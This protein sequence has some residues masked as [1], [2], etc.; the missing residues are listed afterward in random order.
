VKA[1]IILPARKYYFS[2]KEES[3]SYK[4]LAKLILVFSICLGVTVPAAAL[5]IQ[6]EDLYKKFYGTDEGEKFQESLDKIM[7]DIVPPEGNQAQRTQGNA[8]V[9]YPEALEDYKE[10]MRMMDNSQEFIYI[11]TLVLRV[12]GT[13]GMQTAAKMM[14]KKTFDDVDGAFIYHPLSQ[15]FY[16]SP[17]IVTA[18]SALG[19]QCRGYWPRMKYNVLNLY[20]YLLVGC[21]KKLMLCDDPD[22]GVVGIV[23]G[24]NLGDEYLTDIS[25]STAPEKDKPEIEK[26]LKDP[27]RWREANQWRDTD[28]VVY[29]PFTYDLDADFV[30]SFNEQNPKG[31]KGLKVIDRTKF[32]VSIP[33]DK[34]SEFGG[35]IHKNVEM[36]LIENEPARYNAQEG[37]GVIQINP[38]YNY[39]IDNA[40]KYIDIESP[41]FV[42]TDDMFTPLVNA[43]KRGVKIRLLTNSKNTNDMGAFLVNASGWFWKPLIEAGAEVYLWDMPREKDKNGEVISDLFRTMHSKIM[44]VDKSIF[45]QSSFNYDGRGVYGENEWAFPANSVSLSAEA[46][47]IIDG[48]F[49]APHL[50]KVTKEKYNEMFTEKDRIMMYFL[51]KLNNF[52]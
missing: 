17:S 11:Y 36:R 4:A 41:Y 18:M 30:R 8:V 31:K 24:R 12:A 44:V 32:K 26:I 15:T 43:A 46:Q 28:I 45:I 5:T 21:H 42:P 48:D 50:I 22:Y 20:K 40:Q 3:M 47:R 51:S 23:G 49:Q 25:L 52:L 27:A 14:A 13:S 6:D 1:I 38:Y 39:L 29:G 19:V 34:K 7:S 9:I 33:A 10:R 16:S 35:P 37:E 2:E